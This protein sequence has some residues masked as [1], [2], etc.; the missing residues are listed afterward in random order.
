M[1]LKPANAVGFFVK[2]KRQS[3]NILLGLSVGIKYS[4]Y[5][6]IWDVN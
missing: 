5:D 3:S 4:T 2:L 1:V 6:L